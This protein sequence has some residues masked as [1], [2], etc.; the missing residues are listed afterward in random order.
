[1]TTLFFAVLAQKSQKGCIPHALW[2]SEW[3]LSQYGYV[4][5]EK[6]ANYCVILTKTDPI[7]LVWILA[8]QSEHR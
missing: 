8:S 3:Q 5:I 2:V 1:M 6:E 4:T 7:E